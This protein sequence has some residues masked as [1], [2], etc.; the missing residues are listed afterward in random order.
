MLASGTLPP[1]GLHAC[2]R[3]RPDPYTEQFGG[4]AVR[5]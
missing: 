2:G 5:W 3:R 4:V 1:R